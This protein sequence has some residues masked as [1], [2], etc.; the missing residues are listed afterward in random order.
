M[1]LV[2][3]QVHIFRQDRS[4]VFMK[5]S[6]VPSGKSGQNGLQAPW[7]TPLALLEAK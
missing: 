3:G 5:A 4:A 1:V 7:Q 6:G 2:S